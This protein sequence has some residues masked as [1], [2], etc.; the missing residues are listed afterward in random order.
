MPAMISHYFLALKALDRYRAKG[1]A[2]VDRDAFLWGA[3][4]P[5]FLFF[6]IPFPWRKTRNLNTLGRRMHRED[7]SRLLTAFRAYSIRRKSDDLTRSYLLGFLCHYSMDRTIHPFIYAQIASLRKQYPK[8]PDTFLH[9]Q[10]ESALDVIVL[11]YEKAELPTEFNL[12]K[13]I[14]KNRDVQEA[15]AR[16]YAELFYKLYGSRVQAG[17]VLQAERDCRFVVGLQNDRTGLKKQFFQ[18]LEKRHDKYLCSCF[19]RGVVEEEGFDYANI[20]SSPWSWPVDSVRK[21][22][23]SFFDLYKRSAEESARFM[24]QIYQTDDMSSLSG[25]IPFS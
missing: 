18:R 15:I 16:I 10:I 2:P 7:P 21:R 1:G 23:E 6:Q 25:K 3:Q 19:F 20:L 14:P 4:G 9:C 5:D 11:R 17:A 24:L 8:S 12:K 13:A 22:S